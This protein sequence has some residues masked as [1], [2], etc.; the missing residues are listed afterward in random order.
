MMC[1]IDEYSEAEQSVDPSERARIETHDVATGL[2][3]M[4]SPDRTLEDCCILVRGTARLWR[5]VSSPG[6]S[7]AQWCK[8]HAESASQARQN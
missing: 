5:T 2:T 1:S 8:W 6:V 7:L 3:S 4:S